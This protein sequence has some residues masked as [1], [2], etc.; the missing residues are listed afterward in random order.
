VIPVTMGFDKGVLENEEAQNPEDFCLPNQRARSTKQQ[1]LA[2][3]DEVT[4]LPRFYPV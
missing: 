3:L 4:C 2:G 1:E